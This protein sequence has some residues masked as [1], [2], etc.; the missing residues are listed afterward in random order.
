MS[1]HVAHLGNNACS[2]DG[3]VEAVRLFRNNEFYVLAEL[4]DDSRAVYV[5]GNTVNN[6]GRGEEAM[7]AN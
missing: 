2:A 1:T 5:I 4:S 3:L 7:E 6:D